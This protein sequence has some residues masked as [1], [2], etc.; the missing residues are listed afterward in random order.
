MNSVSDNSSNIQSDDENKSFR[1][2]RSIFSPFGLNSDTN[3]VGY[4]IYEFASRITNYSFGFFIPI[5]IADLGDLEYGNGTG[6]IIWGYTSAVFSVTTVLLYLS[7]VPLME[8]EN[9]KRKALLGSC[10][11]VSAAHI[12][13]IFCFSPPSVIFAI[14]L[15]IT[16]KSIQRVGDVA[17]ESFLDVIAIGK[18]AHEI[19]TRSNIMGYSGMLGF[20]P[21]A[22]PIVSLIYFGGRVKSS[23]WVEGIVPIVCCGVWYLYFAR[24]IGLMMN[25][26]LGVGKSLPIEYNKS[27]RCSIFS[28]ALLVSI[29]EHILNIKFINN[30]LKDLGLFILSLIFLAGA[31][32]TAVSVGAVLAVN[33]LNIS[34]VYL[35]IAFFL[36]IIAAIIGVVVYRY[37]KERNWMNPKQI[38]L[39]NMVILFLCA[40]YV[41]KVNTLG[42]IIILA[43]VSGS[44][45]GSVGAFT[46]SML[47]ILIPAE[48]QSR[49]FS[50]YELTQDSTSW[51]GPLII[52]SL[53][54]SY[55][56]DYYRE[57]VAI[58]CAVQFAI[59]M[60]ILLMVD[61]NRGLQSRRDVEE[62]N[63]VIV[64]SLSDKLVEVE[65]EKS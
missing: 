11:I 3:V 43:V 55:G 6:R 46:R 13:F 23:I 64:T 31:A 28:S 7:C 16:G 22:V 53:A 50:F 26:E 14:L 18:D 45:V 12:L 8:F 33:V 19:S 30:S 21:F 58:V 52:S 65:E 10:A 48:R 41:L 62:K 49:L 27:G 9:W 63:V 4:V 37:I 57:I 38:L 17:F 61:L 36:G 25:P 60:P 40:L 20:I 44:Q 56:N 47:S 54:L 51:I 24:Y 5:L 35:F 29:K 34:L 42:D 1:C 15:A 32:S 59:G 2:I 39:L